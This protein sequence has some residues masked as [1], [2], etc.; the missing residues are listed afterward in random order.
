[1]IVAAPKHPDEIKSLDWQRDN[2][3]FELLER[4]HANRR[5][6]PE[7]ELIHNYWT[8]ERPALASKTRETIDADFTGCSI[9]SPAARSASC[10][11]AGPI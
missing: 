5:D 11:A 10:L 4:A 6:D 3:L 8:V 2:L 1:M 9:R 7:W